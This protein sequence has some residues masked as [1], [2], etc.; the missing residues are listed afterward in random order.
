MPFSKLTLKTKYDSDED[1]I[2]SSF[3]IP[4]LSHAK[5][6][7]RAV[8]YF[9]S[10]VLAKAAEGL[11]KFILSNGKM[12]LII[13]DPLLDDEYEAVLKGKCSRIEMRSKE[14]SEILL[15][16]QNKKLKII[17][18]LIAN[19]QLEIKFAFTHKGMFHKKV[20]IFYAENQVVV[21]SGS[22]NE[23]LAGLTKYNS[24]E[25]SVFFSWKSSFEDYGKSELS[26]FEAL[27]NN[28]KKRVKVISLNSSAYDKIRKSTDKKAI[29]KELFKSFPSQEAPENKK[30]QS[31]FF[32]Y[33]IEKGSDY[34]TITSPEHKKPSKPIEV[35]GNPFK[36]F[37][38]QTKAIRKWKESNFRGLFKLA[39]GAGKT[40]TSICALVELY[41]TSAQKNEQLF[42]V[43]TV[44][45]IELANQW[46]S[47]LK[48]F[49]INAIPCFEYSEKWVS[50]LDK[51]ILRFNSGELDFVC[52][53]VVN[54][55]LVGENFQKRIAKIENEKMLLI[56]DECHHLAGQNLFDNLPQCKY[57]IGLSATPFR[58]EDEE[59][60]GSPFENVAKVNLLE[61]FGGIVSEYTLSNAI[62]SKV[63]TPYTYKVVAVN[64]TEEEQAKY[65]YYSERIQKLILKSRNKILDTDEKQLLTN[66]CGLRSRLLATCENKLPALITYLK[67]NKNIQ[68]K[69]SLIYVGEGKAL[70]EEGKYILK[71]TNALHEQGIK[72]AKFTSEESSNERKSIMDNFKNEKIDALV[73][74]K[75]LDEGIDVPVCRSAFIMASTRNPRQYVQR[76]GRVL[77]KALGKDSALI[78]DFVV[79][80]VNGVNNHFSQNLKKAELD[81]I[82][83]FMLTASNSKEIEQ[84]ILELG[85]L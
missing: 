81:R 61:Y 50:K 27:W 78:V 62:D 55:S 24:E 17:S 42:V 3:H 74:M 33:T 28:Q 43:V 73:A 19:E 47:E 45:Y 58:D 10:N 32:K 13:G 37:R 9:S 21:F 64:L 57:R 70:D 63:L 4:L 67:T 15:D 36:L 59:L 83:D 2:L 31:P 85:I 20:G 77:R 48:P 65:E 80:P 54:R 79:L 14:L 5:R 39:T 6:Y 34:L 23:T 82:E 84:T 35:K 56:G 22:A 51:R 52:V 76:R 53:V 68:L 66:Y 40:F 75:V 60:E 41:E 44:P 16:T 8:G 69:H 30:P 71:V 38:H 72:V 49:N 29:Y 26:N 18:Y 11:E 12:R 46:I 7:D 25:I 1:D